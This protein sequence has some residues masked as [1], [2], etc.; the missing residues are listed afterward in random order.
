MAQRCVEVNIS[1]L[2]CG[3]AWGIEQ[4]AWG[5]ISNFELRI[6]DWGGIEHRAEGIGKYSEQLAASSGQSDY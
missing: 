4:G 3:E 2:R 5:V 6:G 1:V